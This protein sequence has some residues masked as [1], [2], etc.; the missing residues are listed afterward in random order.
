MSV[1]GDCAFV[2]AVEISSFALNHNP[3]PADVEALEK[4][5]RT[6]KE[7]PDWGRLHSFLN[8]TLAEVLNRLYL[9]VRLY[10]RNS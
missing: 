9:A 5:K 10:I 8:K 3:S 1:P 4:Y 7:A 2:A 6:L